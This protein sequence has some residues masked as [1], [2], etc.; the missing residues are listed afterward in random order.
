MKAIAVAPG[1]PNSVR[2]AE[3]LGSLGH[4]S[5]VAEILGLKISGALGLVALADHLPHEAARLGPSPESCGLV[6]L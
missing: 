2:L 5:A 1:K 4:R 6:D 3:L